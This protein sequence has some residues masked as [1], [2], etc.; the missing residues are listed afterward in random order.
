LPCT[1][2]GG[3]VAAVRTAAHPGFDRAA[4]VLDG[5]ALDA[6][7]ERQLVDTIIGEAGAQRGGWVVTVNL[8]ILRSLRRDPALRALVDPATFVVADGMPLLWAARL[9][10]RRLPARVT[11]SS[12]IWSL[13]AA[14]QGGLSI[15]LLGGAPGVPEA[16][17][18]A[19]LGGSPGLRVAGTDS[20]PLGFDA[21]SAALDRVIR[22]ARTAEP[23]IVF[24]GLGFPRQERVIAQLRVALP[25]AWFVGCGAAIPFAAGR[26]ERAP[27]WMQRSGLEWAHR[28]KC[29]PRRLFRRYIIKGVPYG[30]GLLLRSA[31][32]RSAPSGGAR[33]ARR[34]SRRLSQAG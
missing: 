25:H 16:A 2:G 32:R 30:A 23:D 18:D 22:K 20:P 10:R 29:E 31:L 12:L 19:L 15:Y 13:S 9:A 8:D 1:T 28:L 7:T 34:A 33:P 26:Q 4:V 11:G 14:A 17:A 5:V 3:I 27:R 24:C 21:D 6:C